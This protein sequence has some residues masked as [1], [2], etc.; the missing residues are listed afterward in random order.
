MTTPAATNY[1]VRAN[2]AQVLPLNLRARGNV[3]YFSSIVTRST[4]NQNPYD[5]SSRT[6]SVRGNLSGNWG[7]Q[8]VSAT[9]DTTELFYSETSSQP[10]GRHAAPGLQP[11]PEPDRRN[12]AVLQLQRRVR[13]DRAHR[14][15]T[16]N[17]RVRPGPEP[18]R[19]ERRRC[20]CR[21]TSWPYLTFNS[22]V[23][24]PLHAL[25][26]ELR[27]GSQQPRRA[28][29]GAA[30]AQ[31]LGPAHR[32][33]RTEVHQG[34]GHAGQRLRGEVQ[35]HHRADVHRAAAD[36]RSTTSSASPSSRA[37]TSRTAARP[38]S[39]TGSS[40]GSPPSGAAARRR[41]GRA[42]S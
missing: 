5:W 2:V 11:R 40:T 4:F 34:V 22:S 29:R 1:E 41:R 38:A 32:H 7:R 14:H 30:D 9:Y 10:A 42:T 37:T 21:S 3:D 33:R 17:T 20:G 19:P 27:Q 15:A 8:S 26:R 28:G 39:R 16:A 31:L 35:A 24:L 6:R 12:A 18:V 13:L 36:R 23:V 25:Q